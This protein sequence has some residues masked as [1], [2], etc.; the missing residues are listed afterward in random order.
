M[1]SEEREEWVFLSLMIKAEWKVAAVLNLLTD[2][3][4]LISL[5]HFRKV[6]LSSLLPLKISFSVNYFQALLLAS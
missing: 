4:P 3:G 5:L 1:E 2:C 6:L